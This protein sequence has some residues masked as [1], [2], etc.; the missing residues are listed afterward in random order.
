MFLE[1][2]VKTGRAVFYPIYKGTFER[3]IKS[4][5]I[6]SESFEYTEV[7]TQIVKDFKRSIDYLETRDDINTDK[8]AF[9]GMSWGAAAGTIISAVEDRIKTNIYV[10]GG[11]GAK[12]RPEVWLKNFLSRVE[13]PTIMLNGR[14][15]DQ[16]RIKLMYDLIGTNEKNKKLVLFESHHIP[17]HNDLVREVLAWLDQYLGPVERK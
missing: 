17:P 12:L 1:F 8:I 6:G 13:A 7:L 10:S 3:S 15:E 16:K 4:L 2:V 11:L 14:Y 5:S 9:Y